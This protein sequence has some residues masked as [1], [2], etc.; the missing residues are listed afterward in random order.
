MIRQWFFGGHTPDGLQTD[1]SLSVLRVSAGLMMA[2]G[3]GLNKVPPPE[4]FVGLIGD[5]GLP[6]PLVFAWMAGLA[7][8]VGGVL[9]A[10]GL[11]TRWCALGILGAML[12]AAFLAHGSDPLFAISGPSKELAVLYGW[13]MLVF[14]T[15]GAGRFSL[16]GVLRSHLRRRQVDR[17]SLR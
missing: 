6:I 11:F 3:H 9:V 13:I 1:V 7:E 12:V 14:V 15:T 5:M 2:A 10:L 8:G 16:D 17:V 4:G